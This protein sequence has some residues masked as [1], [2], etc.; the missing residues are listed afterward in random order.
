MA[1]DL[2]GP[3]FADAG[4]DLIRRRG[5]LAGGAA[6]VAA[7]IA[8]LTGSDS[9]R[10]GHDTN[11]AYDSQTTMH[12]DVTNT[13]SGS[14]R[15]SSNISGTAAFVALNNYP[16]GISRPDG[17]LGRTTYTTSNC[18]GVA[19]AN[20]AASGGIGVLGT[21]N[22]A[23]GTGVFG[24]AGSSVPFGTPPSGTG[25]HGNGPSFGV[26]GKTTAG[27]GV[28]GESTSSIGV[29]GLSTSG[30]GV[31]GE[32]ASSIGVSGKATGDSGVQGEA[33]TGRGVLGKSVSVDGVT[34]QSQSGPGVKGESTDGFGVHGVVTGASTAVRGDATTGTGVDGRGGAEGVHGECSAADGIGSRGVGATGVRGDT[35]SGVGVLGTAGADGVAGRFAGRTVVEGALAANGGA[36]VSGAALEATAGATVSGGLLAATAGVQVSGGSLTSLV[37]IP[38]TSARQMYG[39]ES[40]RPLIEHVGEGK[41]VN[42]NATIKLPSYL[43]AL[44]NKKAYQ[45]FLTE[46]SNHGGLY[47]AARGETS[48]SVRSRRRRGKGRFG[49]RVVARRPDVVVPK[50]TAREVAGNI[51]WSL[52]GVQ[53]PDGWQ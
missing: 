46:Y 2:E 32:S 14:T 13:T 43:D 4:S 41:L 47:V 23:T 48:F 8:K 45:V 9:A 10:A 26:N 33:T 21:C 31:Q 44:I 51:A 27:T 15:I 38:G 22:N 52:R 17:I 50:P 6:F 36:T 25:V 3:G 7:T 24:Y 40:T 11:I 42:G 39:Q 34:G 35:V 29:H 30:I 53:G 16:V 20:E 18:A 12:V 49:Y 19:G 5:L 37:P 1:T 28:K